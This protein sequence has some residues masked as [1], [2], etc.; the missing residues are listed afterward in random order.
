[1]AAVA[2]R[3]GHLTGMLLIA[4]PGMPDPRFARSVI[5]LCAHSADGAM[6]LVVNQLAPS[7]SLP[8]VVEQLGIRP[9]IDLSGQPVHVGGPVETG[10]GF[11]LHSPDYVQDST[12]VIDDR[13]ALTA[14]VD[15]LKAIAEGGG[16][17]RRVFALGYAGWAPGQ[18]DQEIQANGW[19]VAPADE[20]LVF[21]EDNESKWQRALG[22]IG[23]DPALLSSAAGRA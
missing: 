5:Y 15:V 16:P 3:E 23:V 11:V 6:G 19:L 13:F 2:N 18:L 8:R 14:T 20:E 9:E 22:R 7:V 12:L 17:R 21:G 10:R 1:M 4:M